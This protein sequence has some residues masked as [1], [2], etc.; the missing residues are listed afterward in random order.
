VEPPRTSY[1]PQRADYHSYPRHHRSYEGREVTIN[2]LPPGYRMVNTR[3]G[4]YYQHNDV[5]YEQ[6][7]TQ[8]VVVN[9]PY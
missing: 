8:Y 3:N 7:G 4:R 2:Q 9:R 5:Y 1:G 6:R